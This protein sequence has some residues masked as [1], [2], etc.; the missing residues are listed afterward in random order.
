MCLGEPKSNHPYTIN[1]SVI[2][3]K[4]CYKDLGVLV[5][6][7]LTWSS[8]HDVIMGIAYKQLGLLRRTFAS[9]NSTAEKKQF[10]L[11]LVRSQLIYCSPTQLVKGW[12]KSRGVQQNTL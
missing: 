10:Y 3:S 11:S 12:K 4:N 7:D 6:S 5:C 1:D 8:H 2:A 9:V